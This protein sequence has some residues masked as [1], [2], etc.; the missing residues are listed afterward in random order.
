MDRDEFESKVLELWTKSQVPLTE[1]N[2]QFFAEVPR[3]TLSGWLEALLKERVLDIEVDDGGE[4]EYAVVGAARSATGPS[5][6][7]E[8][9]RKREMVD[10]AKRRILAR[11]AGKAYVP[12]GDA[13]EQK[14]VVSRSAQRSD[15]DEQDEEQ[16]DGP[17]VVSMVGRAAMLASGKALVALDKPLS[18]L[19]KPMVKGNKSLLA[20]AGLS[21]FGP[22]GWLYAG[23]F[24]EAV[25]A[26]LAFLAAASVIGFVPSFLLAPFTM[27]G[28]AASSLVGLTYAWRFN[29][30]KGRTP[31]LLAPKKKRK[32]NDE[33]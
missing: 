16:D 29:R 31:L 18:M 21:L 8:Y 22:L 19:D 9:Q 24:R 11:R 27:M 12:D 25:P 1:A 30:N 7:E 23:S 17:G 26:S 15:D 4:V 20:S 2:L 28:M 3:R 32:S 14:L 6:C 5:S 13:S 33:T 10:E